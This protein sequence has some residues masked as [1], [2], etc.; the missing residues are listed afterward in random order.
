MD[1]TEHVRMMQYLVACLERGMGCRYFVVVAA[2]NRGPAAAVFRW[3]KQEGSYG[4]LP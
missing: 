3:G 1:E 2:G 4:R